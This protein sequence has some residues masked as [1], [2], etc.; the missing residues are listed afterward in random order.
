MPSENSMP[1]QNVSKEVF[2]WEVPVESVPLPSKGVM[3]SPNSHLYNRET[4]KI[5][6]MTAHEEDIL[7]S[8]ALIKEN[9]VI[10]YLLKS[11]VL[12]E[13]FDPKE[14]LQGDKLALMIAVRITGYGSDY[15]ISYKCESCG[16]KNDVCVDLA[17]VPI[18]R[19]N[20]D[21]V[22]PGK[23]LFL[24]E[25]PVTKKKVVF[26][27][28]TGIDAKDKELK[29]KN[30]KKIINS[31]IDNTITGFL[32]YSIISIDGVTDKNQINQFIKKMP[33]YDSKS[34]RRFIKD[35]EPGI[36]LQQKLNCP[37]C[38]EIN[39]FRLPISTEFFWPGT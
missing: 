36:D 38:G 21:P 23:N 1:Q 3:Y 25:L 14:L 27:F 32:E 13:N 2:N 11:C 12:E 15:N 22:E 30:I 5:K 4:L 7:A 17:D 28:M 16:S 24:Y 31:K 34:L 19:L 35:N 33:A 18:K 37:K 6:A 26:K 20:I 8:Q 9:L 29:D 39:S 10:D